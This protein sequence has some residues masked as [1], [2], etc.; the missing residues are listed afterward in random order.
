MFV[1]FCP[2][3]HWDLYMTLLFWEVPKDGYRNVV[4]PTGLCGS[5]MSTGSGYSAPPVHSAHRCMPKMPATSCY[6]AICVQGS[7]QDDRGTWGRGYP[8]LRRVWEAPAMTARNIIIHLTDVNGK[9]PRWQRSLFNVVLV[10]TQSAM[11]RFILS[12]MLV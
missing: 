9:C 5:N 1:Y 6:S 3:R 12:L 4:Q 8:A 10:Q 11:L 7:I 2:V